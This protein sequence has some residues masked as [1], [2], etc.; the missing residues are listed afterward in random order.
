MSARQEFVSAA[1]A[2]AILQATAIPP[3]GQLRTKQRVGVEGTRLVVGNRE[4]GEVRCSAESERTG[5]VQSVTSIEVHGRI[6]VQDIGLERR[7]ARGVCRDHGMRVRTLVRPSREVRSIGRAG[8]PGIGL[9]PESQIR[10]NATG[11][12]Q[13]QAILQRLQQQPA[14][15]LLTL[16]SFMGRFH[17]TSMPSDHGVSLQMFFPGSPGFLCFR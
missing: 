8:S 15:S 10:L 2:R 1:A 5:H 3:V 17:V 12:N 4:N 11:P 16:R 7:L 13:Q 9:Q 14:L 6:E